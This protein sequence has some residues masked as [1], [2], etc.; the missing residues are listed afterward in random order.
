MSFGLLALV[1]ILLSSI[2][3]TYK[4]VQVTEY[5]RHG[6][7]TAFVYFP[8]ATTMDE[9]GPGILTPNGHRMHYMLGKQLREKYPH[10]FNSALET[11]DVELLASAVER[12]HLSAFS[13]IL[14]LFPFGSGLNISTTDED[15]WIPEYQGFNVSYMQLGN[16]S[17]PAGYRPY[18]LKITSIEQDFLFLPAEGKFSC[19]NGYKLDV[20]SRKVA[21][22]KFDYVIG[23]LGEQLEKIGIS[24]KLYLE[25][26]WDIGT[27][28]AF[29]SEIKCYINYYGHIPPEMPQEIWNRL[30]HFN[31]FKFYM[32][33]YD[34]RLITYKGEIS[35]RAILEGLEAFVSDSPSKKK[36]RLFSGHDTG[37]YPHT[38]AFNLTDLQC[39]LDLIQG[40]TPTRRCEGAPGFASNYI[41]ELATKDDRY[42]V[43][44]LYNNVPVKICNETAE[45]YC[46]FETFRKIYTKILLSA[47]ESFLT[48]CGN[49]KAI[50]AVKNK[51]IIDSRDKQLSRVTY[52][53][54]FSI[55]LL[56]AAIIWRLFHIKHHHIV[57]STSPKQ[58]DD[59]DNDPSKYRSILG[60]SDILDLKMIRKNKVRK[61]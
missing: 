21:Y 53:G 11:K 60:E 19:P 35:A 13:Q 38:M 56:L 58:K 15:S 2:Q 28:G 40:R 31:D 54:T 45:D 30:R 41:Y 44:V 1:A 14:G 23:D 55:L 29:S 17:L 34:K 18:P 20:K 22:K 10:I 12:T 33:F 47:E 50:N 16:Y 39:N 25:D 59:K 26:R 7:R 3:S 46:E 61:E 49:E 57:S 37:L 43:R 27:L 24:S 52:Y 36:F 48:I 6:A 5:C 8:N 9:L 32:D 42:Y 51:E 4:V